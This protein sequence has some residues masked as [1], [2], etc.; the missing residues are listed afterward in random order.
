MQKFLAFIRKPYEEKGMLL[1]TCDVV[2]KAVVLLIWCYLTVVLAR[3]FIGSLLSDYNPLNKLWWFSYCFW[4][5]FG[6]S[7][8]TYIVFFV[9]DYNED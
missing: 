5:F 3:L 8:L 4:I 2:L 6:A 1:G 7:W 9:R